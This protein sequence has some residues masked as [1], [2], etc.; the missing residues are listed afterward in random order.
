MYHLVF[1]QLFSASAETETQN[2]GSLEVFRI[3]PIYRNSN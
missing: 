2:F 3:F 1:V